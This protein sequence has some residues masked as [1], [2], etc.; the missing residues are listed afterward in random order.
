MPLERDVELLER[1]SIGED[2]VVEVI[3]IRRRHVRIRVD[4]PK[5]M[6]IRHEKTAK[7]TRAQVTASQQGRRN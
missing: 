2:V 7:S 3:R 4:A 1:I 6:L 5:T